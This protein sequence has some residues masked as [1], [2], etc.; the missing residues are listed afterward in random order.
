MY[1]FLTF[2]K[3][4]FSIFMSIKNFI[5][6]NSFN[7]KDIK[8]CFPDFLSFSTWFLWF[9]QITE[10]FNNIPDAFICL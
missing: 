8:F 1:S 6:A 5:V 4:F 7:C 10:E 3:Y 2:N 9:M